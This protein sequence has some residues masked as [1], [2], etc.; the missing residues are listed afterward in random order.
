MVA[1]SVNKTNN[2]FTIASSNASTKATSI[3]V[4]KLLMLMPGKIYASK[5]AFTAVMSTLIKNFMC[6]FLFF[7]P[8]SITIKK[9]SFRLVYPN[10]YWDGC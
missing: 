10:S 3:A 5:K 1:G 2:G 4:K 8:H 9:L 7:Q 6:E